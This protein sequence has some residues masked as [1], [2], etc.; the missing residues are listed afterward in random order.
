MNAQL[1]GATSEVRQGFGFD[2]GRLAEYLAAAVSDFRGPLEVRQFTGGQSNPTYLLSTAERRYVLRRKPPGALLASA[3]AIDREYRVMSALGAATRVPVPRT[4][5]LCMDES[6]IGTAFYVMEHVAGRIFWDVSLPEVVREERAAYFD[7]M[8]ATL[9][10]LHRVDPGAAGLTDFGRTEGYLQRQLSRWSRQYLE[11][12]AAGRVPDLDRLMEWLGAHMPAPGRSAVI[13]GDFRCDNLIFHATE[14]RVLAVL[15]WELSTL[16]DPL[17]DFAYHLLM[18]N[19][20]TIAFPGLAGRDLAELGI[21]SQELSVAAYC[22]RTGRASIPDLDF[23]IAFNLF[24]SAAICHGIRGRLARGTAASA[25][26]RVY[27]AAVEQIAAI[28]WARARDA[29]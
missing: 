19:L 21:P 15:D 28:G 18:Y 2:A 25:R 26:A 29:R 4:F 14:P 6:V 16:G 8:N 10:E 5:A 12:D 17:A 1:D 3:H 27:A 9:A 23:Y 11:D 13:H 24:K 20:P 22:R 7:A